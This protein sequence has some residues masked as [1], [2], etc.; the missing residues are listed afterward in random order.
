[1]EY[2]IQGIRL[3]SVITGPDGIAV[4]TP[5]YDNRLYGLIIISYNYQKIHIINITYKFV[6]Q[7]Q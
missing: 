7:A 3:G 1:M 2:S 4:I 5:R 6:H